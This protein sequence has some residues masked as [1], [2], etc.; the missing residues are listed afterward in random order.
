MGK[1]E[2]LLKKHKVSQERFREYFESFLNE[3]GE[4]LLPNTSFKDIVSRFDIQ[5]F[6]SGNAYRVFIIKENG[7]LELEARQRVIGS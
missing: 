5:G 1:T 6:W 2:S 7:M 4:F 3:L